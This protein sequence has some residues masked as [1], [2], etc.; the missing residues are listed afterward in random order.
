MA[1]Q[2]DATQIEILEGLDA[3]R[4][5]PGMYIGSTGTR[6]L[7]HLVWEVVDNAIDEH[8]AGYGNRLEV[9]IHQ[10]NWV[11]VR[12]YG[13]GIPVDIHPGTNKPAAETV[14]TT[15]HA[16]GKFGESGVYKVSGGLHGVGV[17][18]VNALSEQLI[19]TVQRDGRKYVQE[20]SR[21]TPTTQLMDVG[22]AKQTGTTISFLPDAEIFDSVEWDINVLSTR[23][24]EYAFLNKG[25]T[26][27]LKDERVEKEREETYSYQGGLV[28]FVEELTKNRDPLH[29]EIFHIDEQVE[30]TRIQV[31]FRYIDSPRERF[32][33]FANN[34]KTVDGGYHETG[35]KAALTRS[36]NTFAKNAGLLKGEQLLNGQDVREG[37]VCVISVYLENPQFEGQTKNKLGNS[38]IRGLVETLVSERLQVWLE[39]NPKDAGQIIRKGLQALQVREATRKARE[40]VRRGERRTG[41]GGLPGKLADCRS[42]KVEERELFLVEG[43]SAGGTAKQARNRDTQAILPLRGKILNVERV[44]PDRVFDNEEIKNIIQVLGC[45]VGEDYD[46]SKLRYGKVIILVDADVDGAHISTLLQTFFYRYMRELI[47][48]GRVYFAQPPLYSA[49][50]GKDKYYFRTEEE[51]DKWLEKHGSASVIIQRFKGLGE[52]QPEQLRETAMD[53]KTRTL[54]RLQINSDDDADEIT[55]ILMGKSVVA[56]REMIESHDFDESLLDI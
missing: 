16:G 8:L 31:A 21:G 10:N 51:L 35:L 33:S 43:D 40:A 49:T 37:I 45:G 44:R 23:L 46:P 22:P 20:Y 15:L 3:V 56:R 14:L 41:S 19:L 13:R 47:E 55:N 54:L 1:H 6:G 53:P 48:E 4:R 32:Y 26:I 28:D 18:V 24:K 29:Q 12:D 42:R 9:T 52:M 5:R 34:V 39:N 17:A 36:I 11:T 30:G 38:Y 2:Y 27:F 7:H 50:K 25:I